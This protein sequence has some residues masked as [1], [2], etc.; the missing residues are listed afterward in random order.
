[1]TD[2]TLLPLDL[3]TVQR[4]IFTVDFYGGNQSCNAGPL[5]LRK[6]ERKARH[7]PGAG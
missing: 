3:P 1:M 5:L 7:L 2:A 6:A 4:K